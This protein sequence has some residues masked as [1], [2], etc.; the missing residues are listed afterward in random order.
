MAGWSSGWVNTDGT[1]SVVNGATLTF[2]HSLGTDSLNIQVYTADDAVGLNMMSL[3]YDSSSASWDV[4]AQIKTV[5]S[6]QLTIQLGSDGSSVF[7]TSGNRTYTALQNKYIKVVATATD[8]SPKGNS[9]WQFL[10]SPIDIK[11]QASSSAGNWITIPANSSLTNSTNLLIQ[12]QTTDLD[13]GGNSNCE[14]VCR[15][16]ASGP[17]VTIID[18]D[19]TSG[20]R[21]VAVEQAIIPCNSDGSFDIKFT[22][23]DNAAIAH[24]KIVGYSLSG[25][26]TGGTHL[27]MFVFNWLVM[28]LILSRFSLKLNLFLVGLTLFMQI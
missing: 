3:D 15:E 25:A 12:G 13:T 21:S 18:H 24:L 27:L 23:P 1:T 20:Q 28:T 8:S 9:G 26:V 11:T 4:G 6:T 7:D 16:N 5:T 17:E 10:D 2:T 14:L 22:N 19:G